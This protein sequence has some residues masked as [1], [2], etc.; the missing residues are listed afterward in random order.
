MLPQLGLNRQPSNLTAQAQRSPSIPEA[1]TSI[2]Q[3][4]PAADFHGQASISQAQPTASLQAPVNATQAYASV[5]QAHPAIVPQAYVGFPQ[6]GSSALRTTPLAQP[7]NH[8]APSRNVQA[9]ASVAQNGYTP[10]QQN[11]RTAQTCKFEISP[12]SKLKT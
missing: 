9:Q 3:A 5:S 10:A 1:G 7:A 4:L 8:Q 12:S 6:V 11:R 2:H